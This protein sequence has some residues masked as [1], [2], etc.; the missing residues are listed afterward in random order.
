VKVKLQVSQGYKS[1]FMK[2]FNLAKPRLQILQVVVV[3][4]YSRV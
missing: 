2:G 1:V 3:G 4:F